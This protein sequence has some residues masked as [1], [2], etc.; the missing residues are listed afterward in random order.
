ANCAGRTHRLSPAAENWTDPSRPPRPSAR[1]RPDAPPRPPPPLIPSPPP[2][3]SSI[4]RPFGASD[5]PAPTSA[6]CC[7]CSYT[8]TSIPARASA[9]AAAIPPR[10]PPT[11][12][13]RRATSF[14]F[15]AG[16]HPGFKLTPPVRPG[17]PWRSPSREQGCGERVFEP[18]GVLAG[19]PALDVAQHA[20]DVGAGQGPDDLGCAVDR[21]AELRP[22]GEVL[23]D[24]AHV[25]E[26]VGL[27]LLTDRGHFGFDGLGGPQ[28]F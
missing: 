5:T 23:H 8:R 2:S 21:H 24:G 3:R 14:P 4:R 13:A 28:D 7:A 6:S 11:T 25:G 15:P 16:P 10:P 20:P 22:A 17:A 1:R 27:H 9:T 26:A 18:I 12:T 19:G